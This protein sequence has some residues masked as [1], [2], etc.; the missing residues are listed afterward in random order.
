MALVLQRIEVVAGRIYTFPENPHVSLWITDDPFG[1]GHG[2]APYFKVKFGDK[3]VSVSLPEL[4]VLHKVDK[5]MQKP[6][7]MALTF[8]KTR[9]AVLSSRYEDAINGRVPQPVN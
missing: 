5:D 1:S 8:A 4:E 3:M 2:G 7:K 9:V 6:M